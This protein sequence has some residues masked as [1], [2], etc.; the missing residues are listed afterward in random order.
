MLAEWFRQVFAR[1]PRAVV[2]QLEQVNRQL[3]EMARDLH[4]LAQ[5]QDNPLARLTDRGGLEPP[6]DSRR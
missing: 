4:T 6:P 1:R 3:G 5:S 2:A